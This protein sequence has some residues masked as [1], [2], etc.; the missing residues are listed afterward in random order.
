M[1]NPK[2]QKTCRNSTC[3]TETQKLIERIEELNGSTP[4]GQIV[5]SD[6]ILVDLLET[7]DF[8]ISGISQD[9]FNIW[10]NSKDKEAVEQMFFEFTD[11]EFI[12]YLKNCEAE[13]SRPTKQLR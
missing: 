1:V 3:K 11:M 2:N 6:T 5:D 10:K 13:I 12:E 4:D 7:N 8:E 9:V